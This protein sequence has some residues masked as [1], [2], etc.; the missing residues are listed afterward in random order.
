MTRDEIEVQWNLR[1]PLWVKQAFEIHGVK[2]NIT[3]KEV[4]KNSAEIF[5]YL[6]ETDIEKRYNSYSKDIKDNWIKDFKEDGYSETQIEDI[7][8]LHFELIKQ[9]YPHL[10]QELESHVS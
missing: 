9:H 2:Q 5:Q 1:L 4:I 8:R 3:V 7:I 6:D 10:L